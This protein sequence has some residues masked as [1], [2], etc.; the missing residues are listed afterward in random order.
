[1]LAALWFALLRP[2][3][4]DEVD[5]AIAADVRPEALVD[6][7][8]GG[9]GNGDGSGN[10]GGGNGGSGSGGGGSGTDATTLAKRLSCAGPTSHKVEEGQLDVTDLVL[11][12]PDGA[13]GTI[14]ILRDNDVLLV[15]RLDNFRDLDFHFVTP[16]VVAEGQTLALACSGAGSAAVLVSGRLSS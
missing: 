4:S 14:R 8:N 15:E 10:G 5:E 7:G 16:I 13:T 3:I 12:N 11:G 9:G 1:L 6:G 2:A